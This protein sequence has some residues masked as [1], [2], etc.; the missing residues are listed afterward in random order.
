MSDS[1]PSILRMGSR[2]AQVKALQV[3]LNQILGDDQQID[4]DSVFGPKTKRVLSK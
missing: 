1:Q 2:G 3:A 4:D